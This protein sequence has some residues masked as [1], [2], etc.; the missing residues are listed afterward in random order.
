MLDLKTKHNAQ[1]VVCQYI[2]KLG[3]NFVET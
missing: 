1:M 2:I 3:G